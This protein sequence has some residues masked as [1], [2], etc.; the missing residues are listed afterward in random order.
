MAGVGPQRHRKKNGDAVFCLLRNEILHITI[1]PHFKGIISKKQASRSSR[2]YKHRNRHPPFHRFPENC[3]PV[4]LTR[5]LA[6]YRSGNDHCSLGF[7]RRD[8]KMVAV[9]LRR[10]P[11]SS[12]DPRNDGAN[13]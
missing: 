6:V 12:L 8:Q 1:P 4:A 9:E 3:T 13:V 11:I 10:P 2:L 5:S 7:S